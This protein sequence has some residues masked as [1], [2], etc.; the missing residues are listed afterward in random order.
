MFP[1]KEYEYGSSSKD[2]SNMVGQ[3]YECLKCGNVAD[4]AEFEL[5]QK[6]ACPVCGYRVLR[7]VRNPVVRRLKAV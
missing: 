7:K 2:Y 6:I 1:K 4:G 5:R 3:L